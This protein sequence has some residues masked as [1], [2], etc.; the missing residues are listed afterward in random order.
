MDTKTSAP[1]GKK[2]KKPKEDT[3][4][5]GADPAS[6][7]TPQALVVEPV[8]AEVTT[9][10]NVLD[11]AL[12]KASEAD[13][14]LIA[15]LQEDDV[16]MIRGLFSSGRQIAGIRHLRTVASPAG[17][18]EMSLGD[19]KRITEIIVATGAAPANFELP[20]VEGPPP[21]LEES[22]V[23]PPETDH[24]GEVIKFPARALPPKLE[25]I[26]TTEAGR[27]VIKEVTEDRRFELTEEGMAEKGKALAFANRRY[28]QEEARQAEE[29][30][31]MKAILTDLEAEVIKLTNECCDGA[32]IRS[33]K[34]RYEADYDLGIVEEIEVSTGI[35]LARRG[36]NGETAQVPLFV[37]G[38]NGVSQVTDAPAVPDAD[39]TPPADGEWVAPDGQ[40]EAGAEP[41]SG[42]DASE[43]AAADAA[44]NEPFDADPGVEGAE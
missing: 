38:S 7:A 5:T 3:P 10:S 20:A 18:P 41:V 4:F 34:V 12:D 29:R 43:E 31:A 17:G 15:T 16:S 8:A 23:F 21:T 44:A 36:M 1:S 11:P 2:N 24:N 13:L 32:E 30:R 27:K 26:A 39:S 9:S 14:A 40:E 19:A 22:I 42:E 35:V 25:V 37:L 33:T 28:S 6:T